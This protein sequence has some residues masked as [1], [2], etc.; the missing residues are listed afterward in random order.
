MKIDIKIL[1]A[2]VDAVIK[3]GYEI[4]KGKGLTDYERD[5]IIKC[6]IEKKIEEGINY[7]FNKEGVNYELKEIKDNTIFNKEEIENIIEEIENVKLI[8]E[9]Y[10][11][12][13]LKNL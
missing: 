1:K 8:I 5:H 6:V 12:K 10:Y 11:K 2:K 3:E 7:A 9:K 4:A 13:K